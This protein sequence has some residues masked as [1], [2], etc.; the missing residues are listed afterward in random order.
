VPAHKVAFQILHGTD[1]AVN[2]FRRWPLLRIHE[3]LM[4]AMGV[5]NEEQEL[6]VGSIR[7]GVPRYDRAGIREAVS[8]ALIHRDFTL[9]GAV[10]VQLRDNH[11]RVSNPGGFVEGVS[12]DNLL[13]TEPRPRN[14][15]LADTFKRVGLVE[16]TGRGIETIYRG[17]LRNGRQPPDYTLS[18]ATSVNVLLSSDPADLDFVKVAVQAGRISGQALRVDELLALWQ[19]K[20]A[21][22]TTAARLAPALQRDND[23][24]TNV[25]E[26][27]V[28]AG[29]L[30]VYRTTYNLKSDHYPVIKEV[31]DPDL[32]IINHV[33]KHVKI[34]RHKV[35]DLLQC[36]A[37]QATC[38]LQKLAAKGELVKQG[39]GRGTVYVRPERD[40][41]N[42]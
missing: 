18:T 32:V 27:L 19:S 15:R 6:M 3:W 20:N 14:P 12:A 24:A 38:L 2:E 30:K 31:I 7:V 42:K 9:L 33:G 34:T 13:V 26:G 17:Q 4:E 39:S 36:N 28:Q 16:R 8:N 40:K 25:L 29:L 35:L 37:R 23:H 10:H 22:G 1:V 41:T 5:R 21:G 11:V